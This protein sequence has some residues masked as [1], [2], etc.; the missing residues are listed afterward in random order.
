MF[1]RWE[2][3][4]VAPV[5]SEGYS[6]A[7][8]CPRI[9][10]SG[11]DWAKGRVVVSRGQEEHDR[12]C[13]TVRTLLD[14]WKDFFCEPASSGLGLVVADESRPMPEAWT[15]FSSMGR[16]ESVVELQ[17][18]LGLRARLSPNHYR[19]LVAYTVLAEWRLV[20]RPVKRRDHRNRL[21]DDV[22]RVKE[23]VVPRWVLPRMAELAIVGVVFDWDRDVALELPPGLTRKLRPL[24]D[25]D[26]WTEAA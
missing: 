7:A 22:E 18:C 23:R 11:C 15:L 16:W 1:Y 25:S 10:G 8:W 20:D 24:A 19:H 3:L 4:F 14:H 2:R 26:G 17:R 9:H 13:V 12:R 5:G 6:G 21:V